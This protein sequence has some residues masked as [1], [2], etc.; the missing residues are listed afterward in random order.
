MESLTTSDFAGAPVRSE[1]RTDIA[2]FLALAGALWI[3][4]CNQLRTDW[5]VNPQYGYGWVVPL[6]AI[7]LIW[8]RWGSRP[9]PEARKPGVALA[10]ITGLALLA[11]L[12]TRLIEEANPE[13]RFILWAHAL[14]TVGLSLCA[15]FFL[16][17]RPWLRHFA[18]P[19]CFLLLAVP[20]PMGFETAV[21]QNLMRFVATVS[22]EFLDL[23][24][25]PAIQHGNVIEISYGLVGVEEACSG[26]RSLQTALLVSLF[27]GEFY[28][29]NP[30]QRLLLLIG[31]LALAVV[32]NIGRTF[33]L[34]WIAS[35]QG[36]GTLHEWHDVAGFTVVFFVLAGLQALAFWLGRRRTTE[37]PTPMHQPS[38]LVPRGILIGAAIWIVAVEATTEFWYRT[39]ESALTDN[40]RWSVVWPSG[41]PEFRDSAIGEAALAMLRCTDARGVDWKDQSGNQWKMIF[42][43]WD[44]GKNSAQLAKGHRPDICLPGIGLQLTEDLGIRLLPVA[45]LKLPFRQYVFDQQGRQIHVFYCI[46]ED[47]ATPSVQALL[48]DGSLGSRLQAVLAGRRHSGQQVLQ[49]ALSGPASSEDALATVSKSLGSLV[50]Q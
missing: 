31:G 27:L 43:R 4:L 24:S 30:R 45:D 23:L 36:L 44:P 18:F 17:G 12:P 20:W 46:W 1:S 40:A 32:G 5:T 26:V 2:I 9:T 19:V 49:L 42:L 22:V 15:I 21:I 11:L 41:E 48:E 13:W 35:K 14:Q 34:V 25:I 39:H 8:R 6:L 16:G 10:V 50:R 47:R 38:R 7:G 33:F 28:R 37:E 3:L 29:F